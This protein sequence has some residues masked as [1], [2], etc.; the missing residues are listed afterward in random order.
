[1]TPQ[2]INPP[3]KTVFGLFGIELTR[4]HTKPDYYVL[5]V[6]YK[7]FRAEWTRGEFW[8]GFK[9]SAYYRTPPTDAEVAKMKHLWGD[10]RP[11]MCRYL[12]KSENTPNTDQYTTTDPDE[13]RR[14][15]RTS[16]W[17][18]YDEKGNFAGFSNWQFNQLTP[19]VK[20]GE[21]FLS[22]AKSF[23]NT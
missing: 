13:A 15:R 1:M 5:S 3:K 20:E 9:N 11:L 16:T 6:R 21:G 14:I 4:Y 18:T 23:I 7:H 12:F 17:Q 8:Y 2:A 22:K 10:V 19:P